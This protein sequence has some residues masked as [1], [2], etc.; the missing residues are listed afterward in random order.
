MYEILYNVQTSVTIY[1][2]HIFKELV[3]IILQR[4][5]KNMLS[6]V[7]IGKK[8]YFVS[9]WDG[10]TWGYWGRGFCVKSLAIIKQNNKVLGHSRKHPYHPH[11]GNWKLTSPTPFGCPNT[12]TIIRNNF[13]SPPPVGECGSF[14]ERPI[15]SL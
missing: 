1:Y 10:F 5:V 4:S 11:G 12:F 13:V 7:N 9:H 8:Y 2:N 6:L 14:L 15:R 3:N